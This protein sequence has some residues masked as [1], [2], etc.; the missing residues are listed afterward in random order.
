VAGFREGVRGGVGPGKRGAERSRLPLELIRELDRAVF[1]QVWN[2]LRIVK[3]GESEGTSTDG[4]QRHQM[5]K[6]N[7]KNGTRDRTH[8]LQLARPAV[9]ATVELSTKVTD[10][11]SKLRH[12][13]AHELC[14]LAAWAID[15]DSFRPARK[16]FH[17]SGQRCLSDEES[18]SDAPSLE[19]R[20]VVRGESVTTT[21]H[22]AT[23]ELSTK[24][25]DTASK[26]RHTLAHCEKAV[27]RVRSAVPLRR[28]KP[29]R[30]T[31]A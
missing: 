5:S 9:Y 3:G 28:R 15:H 22:H 23:V 6:V 24:V 29:L 26:L 19:R 13:L 14:H 18:P 30:R 25:T 1:R 21:T 31:I 17:E 2:G 4:E 20:T 8:V 10:T 11:A 27:P 7:F 16:R 12:T